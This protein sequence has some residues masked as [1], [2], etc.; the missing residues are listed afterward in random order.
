M[1]RSILSPFDRTHFV[2]DSLVLAACTDIGV[3]VIAIVAARMMPRLF[4]NSCFLIK[5]FLLEIN[6]IEKIKFR[7]FATTAVLFLAA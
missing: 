2:T 4:T 1:S 6:L 7:I 3:E 5:L